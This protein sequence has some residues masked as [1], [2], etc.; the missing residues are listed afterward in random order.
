MPLLSQDDLNQFF[1]YFYM[2]SN[3]VY[4]S[5]I[6]YSFNCYPIRWNIKLHVKT[7][8]EFPVLEIQCDSKQPL[9]FH[10]RNVLS[11]V[12]N[13]GCLYQVGAGDLWQVWSLFSWKKQN[14]CTFELQMCSMLPFFSSYLHWVSDQFLG[15][16]NHF[17]QTIFHLDG[18]FLDKLPWGT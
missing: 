14:H 2:N 10:E 5:K 16:I 12:L 17:H 13:L 11:T 3:F 4:F 9:K 15:L 7:W 8:E 18:F 6:Y 1:R